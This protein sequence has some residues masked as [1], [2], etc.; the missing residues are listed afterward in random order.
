MPHRATP[1][2]ATVIFNPT[3]GRHQADVEA[4]EAFLTGHGWFVRCERTGEKG[5]GT[6]LAREAAARGD[7]VVVVAGGDGSINEAIQG[8]AGTGTALGVLPL[9]TTNVWAREVGVPADDV[10]SAAAILV[11][12]D[13]RAIDLG[14]AGDRFFLLMA[15]LGFDGAVAGAVNLRLKRLLGRGAYGLT[16]AAQ[17]L[18][19]EGPEIVLE[20]DDETVRCRL[21][22][23]V[24][25]NTRRYGGDFS[26]TARA[27]ADDGLLDVVVFEGRRPWEATPRAVSLLLGRR[28]TPASPNYYRTRR[29]RVTSASALPAQIDGDHVDL[30]APLDI[31][32]A[33]A[34]LHVIVPRAGL[35]PLFGKPPLPA[36]TLFGDT[37][38][39]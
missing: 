17:A 4:A 14:R 24:V 18:R 33:P 26:L 28:L 23:A 8:V 9:G 36:P 39:T 15:G 27:I 37:D 34:V 1:T 16:A 12:G 32:A 35:S 6:R 11:D 13:R 25:G 22:L 38:A 19:Y 31:V 30:G 5:A 21:L 7:D 3:A 2:R 10:A 20:M 29:L